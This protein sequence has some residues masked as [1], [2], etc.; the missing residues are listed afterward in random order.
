MRFAKPE[1]MDGARMA[2]SVGRGGYGGGST[3]SYACTKGLEVQSA[4]ID[5]TLG[6]GFKCHFA[7]FHERLSEFCLCAGYICT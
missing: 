1:A 5:A 2:A 4:M 6:R 3:E 7:L